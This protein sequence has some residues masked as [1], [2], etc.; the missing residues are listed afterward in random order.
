MIMDFAPGIEEASTLTCRGPQPDGEEVESRRVTQSCTQGNGVAHRDF[1][2]SPALPVLFAV[3]EYQLTGRREADQ[4]DSNA[5]AFCW[6]C[7]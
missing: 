6:D 4:G 1:S 2:L 7:A 3:W 5:S